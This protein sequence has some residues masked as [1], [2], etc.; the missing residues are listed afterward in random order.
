MTWSTAVFEL[1]RALEKLLLEV[2]GAS[3]SGLLFFAGNTERAV[4]EQV[5][6]D[7]NVDASVFDEFDALD[8]LA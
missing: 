3:C 7:G 5:V 8:R 4:R 6:E 1:V 2:L